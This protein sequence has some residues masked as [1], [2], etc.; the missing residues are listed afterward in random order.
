MEGREIF[1]AHDRTT[2]PRGPAGRTSPSFLA[3]VLLIASVAGGYAYWRFFRMTDVKRSE[4]IVRDANKELGRHVGDFRRVVRALKDDVKKGKDPAQALAALERDRATIEERID[5]AG[6][7][8]KA[9]LDDLVELPVNTHRNRADRIDDKVRGTK[10][11][12]AQEAES[13]KAALTGQ[14]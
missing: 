8:A 12:L 9:R 14:K 4:Y 3:V 6:D 1:P 13:G 7:E 2:A 11:L 5:Q 10:T